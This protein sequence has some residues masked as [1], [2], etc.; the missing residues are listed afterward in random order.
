MPNDLGLFDVYGNVWEWCQDRLQDY[1]KTRKA[2]LFED[3]EG[4]LLDTRD[5]SSRVLRGGAYLSPE[6][7]VRS[8]VCSG[9]RPSV[10]DKAIGLRVARTHP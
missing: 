2:K 9:H 5:I 7:D 10:R 1:P 8:A 4:S 3:V 6:V